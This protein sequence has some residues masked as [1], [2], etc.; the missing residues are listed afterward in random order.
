MGLGSLA[1]T[2]KL[3]RLLVRWKATRGVA[4]KTKIYFPNREISLALI[5]F[6][7]KHVLIGISLQIIS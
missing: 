1:L 5:L 7:N 4:L 3:P 2:N 6:I